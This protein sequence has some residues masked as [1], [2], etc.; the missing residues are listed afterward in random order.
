MECRERA[1]P[2]GAVHR[3]AAPAAVHVRVDETGRD[4]A[5]GHVPAAFDGRYRPPEADGARHGAFGQEQHAAHT[6]THGCEC[7]ALTGCA[8]RTGRAGRRTAAAAPGWW[9]PGRGRDRPRPT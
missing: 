3:V 2:P 9:L 5:V 7:T 8:G 6:F 1:H 4:D